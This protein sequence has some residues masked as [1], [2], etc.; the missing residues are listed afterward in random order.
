[1]NIYLR[2]P[3]GS[4]SL[5]IDD[6]LYYL[7]NLRSLKGLPDTIKVM[8]TN[9]KQVFGLA[10]GLTGIVSSGVILSK[11]PDVI[12]AQM[13]EQTKIIQEQTKIIQEQTKQITSQEQT[14]QVTMQEKTKLMQ[15]ETKQMQ[16]Q[17]KQ[18]QLKNRRK[19]LLF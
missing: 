8:T 11:T 7:N 17:T 13:Q 19:W 6:T 5:F 12:I 16:E 4:P 1:M 15:E 3:N 2:S 18:M 14:K 10:L 9:Y